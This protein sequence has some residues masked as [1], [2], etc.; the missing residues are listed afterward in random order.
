MIRV[1]IQYTWSTEKTYKNGVFNGSVS[2]G[3]EEFTMHKTI[4]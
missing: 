3:K 4:L 1:V 2:N